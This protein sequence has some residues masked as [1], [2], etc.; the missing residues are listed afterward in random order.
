MALCHVNNI[1]QCS[2][3]VLD[4]SAIRSIRDVDDFEALINDARRERN[5]AGMPKLRRSSSFA[6]QRRHV[7][8]YNDK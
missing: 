6:R 3:P 2:R 5:R 7:R 1:P 8:T 4:L